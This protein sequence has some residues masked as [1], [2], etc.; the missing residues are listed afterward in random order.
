M[1]R[2]I[3]VCLGLSV[4]AIGATI[5]VTWQLTAQAEEPDG[6]LALVK[7]MAANPK[8][9]EM[10]APAAPPG[11]LFG[12]AP[13]GQPPVEL[14]RQIEREMGFFE[15]D[16]AAVTKKHRDEA[17]KALA[18]IP[19]PIFDGA[20][21]KGRWGVATVAPGKTLSDQLA[22]APDEGRV[23]IR[24]NPGS[25]ADRAG[26]RASDVLV[27]VAAKSAPR[28]PVRFKQMTDALPSKVPIDLVVLR[29]GRRQEIKGLVLPDAAPVVAAAKPARAPAP[30]LK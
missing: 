24:V 26:I 6:R 4:L 3:L 5:L 13:L 2:W 19:T 9:P 8:N 23:I 1:V 17:L 22:L 14:A 27:E 11:A 25:P 29:K 12:P 18:S 21:P 20:A 10:P 7:V 16:F 28:D 30:C 15:R